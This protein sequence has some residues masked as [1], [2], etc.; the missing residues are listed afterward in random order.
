[1]ISF[2]KKV[3]FITGD[4]LNNESLTN[5]FSFS[6]LVMAE[7]VTEYIFTK[8]NLFIIELCQVF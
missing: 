5:Q 4:W 6:Q 3:F 2:G 1:M 8:K 7:K